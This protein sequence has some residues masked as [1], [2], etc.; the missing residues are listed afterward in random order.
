MFHA[1]NQKTLAPGPKYKLHSLKVYWL[2]LANKAVPNK[3]ANELQ[4]NIRLQAKCDAWK[5]ATKKR[6]RSRTT[7]RFRHTSWW[8]EVACLGGVS[9]CSLVFSGWGTGGGTHKEAIILLYDSCN[10]TFRHR[11]LHQMR[12]NAH[13]G[14][15]AVEP[16]HAFYREASSLAQTSTQTCTHL[17]LWSLFNVMLNNVMG[18]VTRKSDLLN[19]MPFVEPILLS[20]YLYIHLSIYLSS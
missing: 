10:N 19:N 8:S 11:V 1:Y 12:G 2:S 5:N 20:I 6:R 9:P 17:L 18:T 4:L 7:V 16:P 15:W 3:M 13:L 14:M